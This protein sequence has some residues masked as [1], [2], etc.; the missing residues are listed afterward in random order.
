MGAGLRLICSVNPFHR[1]V[2]EA[3]RSCLL[4]QHMELM[5]LT[6]S[7]YGPNLAGAIWTLGAS[8]SAPY[9]GHRYYPYPLLLGSLLDP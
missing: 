2:T 7:C 6:I 8:A 4:S 5:C 3:D 1:T 9:I